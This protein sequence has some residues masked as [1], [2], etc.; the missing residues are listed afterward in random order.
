MIALI[1]GRRC[2]TSTL[3][4]ALSSE[5]VP[6]RGPLD[7]APMATN[8]EGHYENIEARVL[9]FQILRKYGVASNMG[10]E[11]PPQ[12][13]RALSEWIDEHPKPFVIKNPNCAWTFP[14]WQTSTNRPF[15][16]VWCRRD[17]EQQ[18][19]SLT[20]YGMT[21]EDARVAVQ[22]YEEAAQR[23]SDM[24]PHIVVDVSDVD[25]VEKVKR[26]LQ[27]HQIGV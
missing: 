15:I 4:A 9:N 24:I 7:T 18:A 5:G 8:P 27:E 25:R 26:F 12:P 20:K 17:V 6:L 14:V 1:Y 10:G 11:I 19:Q 21:L 23:M 22:R 16:G 2:G 3:T 13:M